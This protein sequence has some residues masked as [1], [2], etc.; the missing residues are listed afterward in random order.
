[1]GS[2]CQKPVLRQGRAE[3]DAQARWYICCRYVVPKDTLTDEYFRHMLYTP[4]T[5]TRKSPT[6]TSSFI[7]WELEAESDL[8]CEFLVVNSCVRPSAVPRLSCLV[9]GMR[10]AGGV[11]GRAE[12]EVEKAKQKASPQA[13][14]TNK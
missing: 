4:R 2:L 14:S 1:M 13:L 12:Q 6:K 8:L 5:R 11:H 9:I 7:G 10:R 3:T